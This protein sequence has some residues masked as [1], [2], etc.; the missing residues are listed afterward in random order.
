MAE[1]A[2]IGPSALHRLLNCP[3]SHT[4]SK[5]RDRGGSSI[6]AAEGTLAHHI[7]EMCLNEG[8][9]AAAFLG[10]THNVEGHSFTVDDE[11]VEH[12]QSYVDFCFSLDYSE[13]WVEE[14]VDL[15]KLWGGNPPEPIFG[16]ADF[17]AFHGE[18]NTLHVVDL[19]YG[20]GDVDPTDN[21]QAQAY[22]LGA[23][24]S[25]GINSAAEV[26]VHIVQPRSQGVKGVKTWRTSGLDLLI[27]GKE[28]LVPGV[29]KMIDP[30]APLVAGD[31]CKFC[32]AMAV[33]PALKQ[34]ARETSRT[35]FDPIPPKPEDL[36]DVELSEILDRADVISQWIAAVRA[37]AST[38]IDTGALVP[39]YKLVPKR[40]TRRYPDAKQVEVAL[41]EQGWDHLFKKTPLSP[42]QI[43]KKDL[44]TYQWLEANGLIEKSSSGTTLVADHDPRD[45]LVQRRAKD[46]FD[47]IN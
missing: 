3:G 39:G 28:T 29:E 25:L 34:I 22:A 30:A 38:R 46:E 11:M 37:E 14:R 47:A 6:Y 24:L 17:V 45:A 8:S 41:T 5:T 43:E 33:C 23:M 12:C 1:H 36:T 32:P 15:A 27:W 10:S 42:A 7:C 9:D 2:A 44:G 40:A 31:H 26:Y 16:T 35:Q 21:P 18:T 4:L 20:R 13:A 19:K